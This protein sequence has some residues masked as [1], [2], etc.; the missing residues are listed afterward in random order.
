[1]AYNKTTWKDRAVEKPKTFAK[2]DNPDG[3]ITLIPSPGTIVEEGTPVNAANMNKI[4]NKLEDLDTNKLGLSGVSYQA[5]IEKINAVAL[6]GALG[7]FNEEYIT[8]I[9]FQLFMYAR[10]EGETSPFTNLKNQNTLND[11]LMNSGSFAEIQAS[12]SIKSLLESSSGGFAKYMAKV[13]GVDTSTINSIEDLANDSSAMSGIAANAE[14]SIG[15]AQN[16][17][18]CSIFANS[19]IATEKMFGSSVFR[20]EMFENFQKCEIFLNN[21]ISFNKLIDISTYQN[22]TGKNT[23]VVHTNNNSVILRSLQSYNLDY[24]TV[25]PPG[26]VGYT[27]EGGSGTVTTSG[28]LKIKAFGVYT[29]SGSRNNNTG[30]RTVNYIELV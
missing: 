20:M 25:N 19:A 6:D 8:S 29:S 21:P 14:L 24:G 12:P 2:Q 10:F 22:N 18:V 15:I 13:G 30:T 27:N 23:T 17:E 26:T 9:G 3:T 1:M 11:C 5:F 4:E 7:L 16:S 28:D